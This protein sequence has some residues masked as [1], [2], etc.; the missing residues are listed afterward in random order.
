MTAKHVLSTFAMLALTA[1]A[2]SAASKPHYDVAPPGQI[3]QDTLAYLTGEGMHSAWHIVA[4]RELAGKNMGKTPVYQWYLSFYAPD[5]EGG[6]KL[7]YRLPNKDGEL[8]S[9]VT[10]AKGAEMYFPLQDVKIVGAA[11]FERAGVQDVV[12]WDHQSGADCGDADVTLFGADAKDGVVQRVHVQNACSLS[13]KIVKR[14][15]LSGVELSGPYYGPKAPMCCPT[16]PKARALLA[17]SDG[18]WSVNPNYYIISAS[19][20]AHR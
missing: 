5:G 18:R 6:G 14:G 20:A 8:L 19:L 3:V 13:T 10:K 9:R 4:S 12:V 15:G 7:V 1:A 17:Y 16:K 11:E 2:G